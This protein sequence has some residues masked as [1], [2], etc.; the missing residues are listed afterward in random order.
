[1][2]AAGVYQ[3]PRG[4]SFI[5]RKR[6]APKNALQDTVYQQCCIA[7]WEFSEEW[8]INKAA[9]AWWILTILYFHPMFANNLPSTIFTWLFLLGYLF[10][11][12]IDYRTWMDLLKAHQLPVVSGDDVFKKHTHT[13]QPLTA[14]DQLCQLCGPIFCG[15]HSA[16]YFEV[17]FA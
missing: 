7:M 3:R 1:M 5:L 2:E 6:P 16:T 8:A 14:T 17:Q 15:F 10:F 12:L 13:K 9:S 11:C 4:C